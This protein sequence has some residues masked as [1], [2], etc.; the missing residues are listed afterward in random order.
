MGERVLRTVEA[1]KAESE[2]LRADAAHLQ[3]S[4]ENLKLEPQFRT[5]FEVK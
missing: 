3:E 4:I 1:S 5:I 2:N